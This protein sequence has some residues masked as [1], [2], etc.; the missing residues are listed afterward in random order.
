MALH[1]SRG[2][3]PVSA[4]VTDFNINVFFR[5]SQITQCAPSITDSLCLNHTGF[6]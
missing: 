5:H 6:F 4:V 2:S 1:L 3:T